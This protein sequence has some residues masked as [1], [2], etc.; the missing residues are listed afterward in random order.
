MVSA[1]NNSSMIR[2]AAAGAFAGALNKTLLAPLDRLKLVVQ[3]RGSLGGKE[4]SRAYA[5]PWSAFRHMLKEEGVLALWRG[6]VS[7]MMIE[8]GTL[9][10][11][12]SKKTMHV[13][14]EENSTSNLVVI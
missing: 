1:D 3:L 13:W 12:F 8:A 5:S 10:L 14:Q 2:E 4:S 6:N 9:S 7:M 11:N